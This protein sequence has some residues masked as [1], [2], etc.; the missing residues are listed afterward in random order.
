MNED[1]LKLNETE[2]DLFGNHGKKLFELGDNE[3]S[4]NVKEN[5]SDKNMNCDDFVDEG[6]EEN[7]ENLDEHLGI[8]SL[9][10]NL[11]DDLESGGDIDGEQQ[12]K[13]QPETRKEYVSIRKLN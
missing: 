4:P 5:R 3:K 7:V 8:F 2:S 1:E 12:C 10:L 9:N 6:D 13:M 11:G